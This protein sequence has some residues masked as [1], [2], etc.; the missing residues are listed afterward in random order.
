MAKLAPRLLIAVSFRSQKCL[1]QILPTKDNVHRTLCCHHLAQGIDGI[2]TIYRCPFGYH[3]ASKFI[4]MNSEAVWLIFRRYV[5]PHHLRLHQWLLPKKNQNTLERT[6]RRWATS[7]NRNVRNRLLRGTAWFLQVS[8]WIP[9][10]FEIHMYELRSCVVDLPKVCFSASSPAASVAASQ[11]EP[12]HSW[13]HL[14]EMS[15]IG[16]SECTQSHLQESRSHH[17]AAP[18]GARN[19]SDGNH[20]CIDWTT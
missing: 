15:N 13:T 5:F 16:K 1:A 2:L 20:Y 8:F 6:C 10:S 4:C 19:C 18:C 11:K 12:K 7:E 17:G 9:H 3:T 14:Q